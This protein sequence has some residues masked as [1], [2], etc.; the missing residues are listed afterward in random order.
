MRN[1]LHRRYRRIRDAVVYLLYAGTIDADYFNRKHDAAG[2]RYVYGSVQ[3]CAQPVHQFLT[4]K[5]EGVAFA[6][7]FQGAC[8]NVAL[9]VCHV[10]LFLGIDARQPHRQRKF[11]VAENNLADDLCRIC[12]NGRVG[13]KAVEP[14]MNVAQV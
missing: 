1:L 7:G 6:H 12:D 13:V 5:Y 8:D 11:S 10:R 14:A 4:E 9:E 3:V 2:A